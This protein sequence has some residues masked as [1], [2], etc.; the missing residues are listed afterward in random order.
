MVPVDLGL[1]ISN[2]FKSQ[3]KPKM[4]LI[5]EEINDVEILEESVNGKKSLYI[6]GPF[7]QTEVVNRNNRCYPYTIMEKEVKRYNEK[8]IK[9]G[10]ALGELNHPVSGP[11][12]N[13]DR[14]AIKITSLIPEGTTFIGKAKLLDTPMGKIAQALVNEGVKL[15]V[16]S[17][18]VGSTRQS[19]KGYIE[20][21]EDF[22]LATAADIV[23]D[24]S[25]PDAFVSSLYEGVEWIYDSKKKTWIAESIKNIIERDVQ[26]RKLTEERKLQ[27][28][29]KFLQLL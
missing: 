12:I 11:A 18:G 3:D 2:K 21:C 26:Q 13:L 24:P 4:K 28:F 8:F 23:H 17:R 6:T 5:T 1:F 19:P 20:V 29:H 9:E 10:R 7:L 15:G 14:V 22:M 25:A 27:H 16:S